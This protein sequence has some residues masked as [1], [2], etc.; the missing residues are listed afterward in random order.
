MHVVPGRLKKPRNRWNDEE[1]ARMLK[2]RRYSTIVLYDGADVGGEPVPGDDGWLVDHGTGI[3]HKNFAEWMVG[4]NKHLAVDISQDNWE[5]QYAMAIT[6]ANQGG[7]VNA[8]MIV[9]HGWPGMMQFGIGELD[10]RGS[11]W[12]RITRMLP[13]SVRSVTLCGCD[14]AVGQLGTSYLR[15]LSQYSQRPGLTI[16]GFTGQFEPGMRRYQG[17]R[18]SVTYR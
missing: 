6:K 3:G 17:Q 18:V 4:N 13:E 8:L 14:V 16:H 9:D 7:G 5:A 15:D 10:P 2:M 1:M 12:T 11:L